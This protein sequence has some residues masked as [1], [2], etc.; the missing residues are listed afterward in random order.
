MEYTKADLLEAKRQI[1]STLH[2][3]EET[4]KTLEAKEQPQ[5]YKSQITLAKN[6]IKAFT[7]ANSL[8]EKE[9]QHL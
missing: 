1:D 6:R 7:L 5:R 4:I 9:L 3:L 2:K 8:I